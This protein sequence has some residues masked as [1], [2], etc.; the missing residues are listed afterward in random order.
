MK[1][2]VEAA[3][4]N[5]SVAQRVNMFRYRVPEELY[6]LKNDPDCLK[7]LVDIP[8]YKSELRKMRTWL[9]SW[10]EKN[11]DPLTPAFE[12]RSSPEKLKAALIDIYGEHY[13][14]PANRNRNATRRR[15]RRK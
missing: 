12:N 10:M 15:A 2:M 11:R 13:T 5:P 14:K 1:A 7:N 4:T 9:H 6:D 3:K 8:D